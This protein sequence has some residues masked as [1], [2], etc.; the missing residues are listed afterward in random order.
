MD[1]VQYTN[2][3]KEQFERFEGMCKHCGECCGSQD[4]DPCVN[5]GRDADTGKYYCKIYE[6]RFGPQKTLSGKMF[7]CVP[8]RDVI[9]RSLLKPNCA[10]SKKTSYKEK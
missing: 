9:N 3:Q 8:I 7:N 2:H 5:L 6:N 1:D 4:G 10:Y